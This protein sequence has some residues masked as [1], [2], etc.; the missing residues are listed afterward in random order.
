LHIFL[1][2]RHSFRSGFESLLRGELAS[3]QSRDTLSS[4][5]QA[6][7]LIFSRARLDLI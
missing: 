6:G 3:T 4:S 5:S 7:Y 2:G 1:N